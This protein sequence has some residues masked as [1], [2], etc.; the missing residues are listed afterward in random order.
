MG[1]SNF[2]ELG[3]TCSQQASKQ[4]SK[5]AGEMVIRRSFEQ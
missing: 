4:A 1:G 5:H 2:D 3:T